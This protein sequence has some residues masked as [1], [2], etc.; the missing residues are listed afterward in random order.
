MRRAHGQP[1][2]VSRRTG[3]SSGQRGGS[4]DGQTDAQ[5]WKASLRDEMRS[6]LNNN[7]CLD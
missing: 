3:Y 7:T 1:A 4:N 2:Q 6:C 5:D